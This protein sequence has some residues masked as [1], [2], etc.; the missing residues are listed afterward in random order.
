MIAAEAASKLG[1]EPAGDSPFNHAGGW[2]Q[3]PWLA[4]LG[5]VDETFPASIFRPGD[6]EKIKAT[7]F[8]HYFVSYFVRWFVLCT[9][10]I[11]AVIGV[12]LVLKRRRDGA[13]LDVPGRCVANAG[14]ARGC[15][16][17]ATLAA[18]LPRRRN[19]AARDLASRGRGSHGGAGYLALWSLIAVVSWLLIGIGLGLVVPWIRPLRR[20]L[21][22]PCQN[23]LAGLFGVIGMKGLAAYWKL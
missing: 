17:C 16:R 18:A 7:E 5:D 10:W 6:N 23:L 4:I 13:S 3:L 11:G 12:I 8:R 21:I 19:V 2:L 9:F 22:D 15:A 14:A 20:L 1:C